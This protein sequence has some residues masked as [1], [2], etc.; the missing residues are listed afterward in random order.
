MIY[1]EIDCDYMKL[2]IEIRDK[3]KNIK[4]Y[5]MESYHYDNI[6]LY[7]RPN[8]KINYVLVSLIILTKLLMLIY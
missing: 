1:T 8:Y 4:R 6:K 3:N 5:I 7:K 2:F